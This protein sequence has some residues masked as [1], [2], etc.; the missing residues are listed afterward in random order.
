MMKYKDGDDEGIEWCRDEERTGDVY[1]VKVSR[2]R[3]EGQDTRRKQRQLM[4]P[5]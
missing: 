4:L 2:C 5:E 1:R 3:S